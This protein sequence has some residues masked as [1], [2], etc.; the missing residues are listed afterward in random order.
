MPARD[1]MRY[2]PLGFN[3]AIETK[4]LPYM[5]AWTYYL[6]NL[7]GDYSV[8][9]AAAFFPVLMF[10]LTIISFFLF[11]REIFVRKI[12]DKKEDNKN[13]LKANLID[14]ISTFFM[15]VIPIFL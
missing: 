3:N 12:S 2:V 5:I 15:I 6:V 1:N 4:L 13:K 9:F 11:T 8:N 10:A 7:F 14:F